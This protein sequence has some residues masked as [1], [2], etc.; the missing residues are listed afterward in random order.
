[1][2]CP[3]CNGDVA[4]R[5]CP[6][7]G[8][9]Q[10]RP[11]DLTL[12]HLIG[13]A[14]ETVTNTDGRVFASVRDLAIRPGALTSAYRVTGVIRVLKVVALAAAVPIILVGY[15]FAIFLITLYST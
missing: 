7:C 6:D 2:T 8:E 9:R 4:T 13:Q 3:T 12:G 15:R 1:M 10:L 14:I 11:S 5:Y